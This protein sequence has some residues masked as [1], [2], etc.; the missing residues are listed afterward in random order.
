MATCSRPG[1]TCL[2]A[3]LPQGL[4][5]SDNGKAMSPASQTSGVIAVPEVTC[6]SIN[7]TCEFV[8][9]ATDGLWDV[10]TSQQVSQPGR[11]TDESRV[12]GP[13]PSRAPWSEHRLEGGHGPDSD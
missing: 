10:L 4:S 7:G 6:E 13:P 12:C 2:S 1:L 11:Q 9:L 8:V 3:W 5:P